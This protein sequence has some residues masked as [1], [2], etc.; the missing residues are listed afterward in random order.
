M[1]LAVAFVKYKGLIIGDFQ[2]RTLSFLQIQKELFTEGFEKKYEEMNKEI[3]QLK[4][5]YERLKSCSSRNVL[6]IL[7]FASILLT[8]AFCHAQI[9]NVGVNFIFL[10]VILPPKYI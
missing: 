9:V 7:C 5:E 1:C 10:P 8:G 4:E 3:N 6:K 2:K